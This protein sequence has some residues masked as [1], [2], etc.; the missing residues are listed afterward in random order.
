MQRIPSWPGAINRSGYP[1]VSVGLALGALRMLGQVRRFTGSISPAHRL[2]R[3]FHKER[4]R[5]A[6]TAG[7]E[8]F[9][10]RDLRLGESILVHDGAGAVGVFAKRLARLH[11]AHVA[12]VDCAYG[13][14][15]GNQEDADEIEENCRHEGDSDEEGG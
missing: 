4:L 7:Q 13:C 2:G 11:A 9:I 1:G 12:V 5:G 14:Q 8:P 10:A 3:Q 15:E 6:L